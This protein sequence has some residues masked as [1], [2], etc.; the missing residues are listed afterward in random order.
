VRWG[1]RPARRARTRW[2]AAQVDARCWL[3]GE[4]V[5]LALAGSHRDGPTV[6]HVYPQSTGGPV[7]DPSLWRLAHNRCN[8]RRGAA[9]PSATTTPPSRPW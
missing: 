6:D 3:C 9:P 7:Y 8:A 4:L 1:S 2:L 5:D